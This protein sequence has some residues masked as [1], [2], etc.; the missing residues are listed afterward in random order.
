MMTEF[1]IS[2]IFSSVDNLKRSSARHTCKTMFFIKRCITIFFRHN[3][4]VQIIF[5]LF[6]YMVQHSSSYSTSLIFGA[7]QNIMDISQ[8][9]SVIQY[10]EQ[11]N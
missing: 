7:Y 5:I 10:S 3:F 4:N 9:I 8:H 1:Y 2:L 11:A 6:F